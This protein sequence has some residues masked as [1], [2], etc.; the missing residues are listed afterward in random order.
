[1]NSKNLFI[2]GAVDIIILSILNNGDS[3]GYEITKSITKL[4][5]DLLTISQNTIYTAI[6]K[7]VNDGMISEYSV[8]VGKKRTRVYYHIEEKGKKYLDELMEDY[9]KTSN[10]IKNILS[11]LTNDAEGDVIEDE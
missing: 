11:K 5:D 6:Y 4:S 2:T 1:M 10:G 8:L 3:Y 7:L 9:K